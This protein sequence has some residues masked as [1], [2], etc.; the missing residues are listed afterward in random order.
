MCQ[1]NCECVV[2]EMERQQVIPSE[3][4]ELEVRVMEL[5]KE[6]ERAGLGS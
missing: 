1:T 4:E 6:F 5:F 2:C 3:Q